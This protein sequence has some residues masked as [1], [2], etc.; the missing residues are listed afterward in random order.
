MKKFTHVL[1]IFIAFFWTITG[2]ANASETR[3]THGELEISN[4]TIRATP[5][6]APVGGGYI[7]I[8]NMGDVPDTLLGGSAAF[9][10]AIEVHEMK[11]ENDI[12]KMRALADGLEIPAGGEVVLKPG[13][14]HLMFMKLGEQLVKGETRKVV[15]N[16]KKAGKIEL[17][18][19]VQD[20]RQIREG[21]KNSHKH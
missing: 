14:Y 1:L 21:M 15:L 5:P 11:M 18:F 17:E 2:T 3:I 13:G 10:A 12:M 7:T 20:L 4:L 16:F 8:K 6:N 19:E 9:A